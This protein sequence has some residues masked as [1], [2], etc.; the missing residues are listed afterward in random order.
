MNL[1][2]HVVTWK[3]FATVMVT[4]AVA[5]IGV[6]W[7]N[8][9]ETNAKIETRV[10]RDEF[11]QHVVQQNRWQDRMDARMDALSKAAVNETNDINQAQYLFVKLPESEEE[12]RD[13]RIRDILVDQGKINSRTP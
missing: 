6:D 11:I 2:D 7:S 12:L 4:F 3:G 8:S 10:S 9:K 13:K 5:L 1:G